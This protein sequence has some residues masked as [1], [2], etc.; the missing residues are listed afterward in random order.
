MPGS[1]IEN[2]LKGVLGSVLGVYFGASWELTWERIVKQAGGMSSSAIENAFE[3][4][5]GNMFESIL[6]AYM[7]GYSQA[8]C[9]SKMLFGPEDTCNPPR[10]SG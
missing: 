8:G 3:S 5:V 4:V 1:A 6:R 10:H 7:G 2:V 9:I